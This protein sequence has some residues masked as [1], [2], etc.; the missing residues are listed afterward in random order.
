[1][2]L[3]TK[4]PEITIDLQDS[5]FSNFEFNFDKLTKLNDKQYASDTALL[6]PHAGLFYCGNII[7]KILRSVDW[8]KYDTILMLSTNHSSNKNFILPSNVR[9]KV[10]NKQNKE[11]YINIINIPT[12]NN[13]VTINTACLENIDIFNKEH[14]WKIIIKFL[15]LQL[16]LSYIPILIGKYDEQLLNNIFK[17]LKNNPKI[18]LIANTDLIHCGPKYESLCTNDVFNYEM[19]VI[20][21]I[22]LNNYVNYSHESK[23]TKFASMCGWSAMNSFLY[24]CKKLE[25]VPKLYT[26]NFPKRIAQ[27]ENHVGYLGMVFGKYTI[28]D[29]L[30]IPRYIIYFANIYI[31]TQ[32]ITDIISNIETILE[33]FI[34]IYSK[35]FIFKKYYGVFVTI[36]LDKQL[37]GCIGT[38]NTLLNIGK[39]IANYA[40]NAAYADS[41]FFPLTLEESLSE[42]ITYSINFIEKPELI[43]EN[44][45]GDIYY[46]KSEIYNKLIDIEKG[47]HIGVHGITLYFDTEFKTSST[48]LAS[49]IVSFFKSITNSETETENLKKSVLLSTL[50]PENIDNLLSKI[51]IE[52]YYKSFN[53]KTTI[54]EIKIYK[55]E[56]YKCIEFDENAGDVGNDENKKFKQFIESNTKITSPLKGGNSNFINNSNSNN[57]K[58]YLKKYLKYKNKYLNIKYNNIL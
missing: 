32:N 9:V 42:H 35:L 11:E 27:T 16:H 4:P 28:D 18:L 38:F 30:K 43:W 46:I 17:F 6:L 14:S 52:L 51:I 54:K 24:L 44:K 25:Y 1:M 39:L 2:T 49:V 20:R 56:L 13:D 31:L 8:E 22:Y 10:I 3:V 57:N 55:I 36:K 33:M 15:I 19:D 26:F 45:N 41:R 53:I 37:R 23:Q 50:T 7:Q 29:L 12:L 47:I 48:F 58:L 34:N 21:Q 40:L 5:W